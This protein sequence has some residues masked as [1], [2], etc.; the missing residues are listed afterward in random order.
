MHLFVKLPLP[1]FNTPNSL[2]TSGSSLKDDAGA[3]VRA[4]LR[5]AGLNVDTLVSW[6]AVEGA[7]DAL[8]AEETALYQ[9]VVDVGLVRD[10]TASTIVT[11]RGLVGCEYHGGL[12]GVQWGPLVPSSRRP[13]PWRSNGRRAAP[14]YGFSTRRRSRMLLLIR[15]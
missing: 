5:R 10:G 13:C 7:S 14:A 3:T 1:P 8:E 4:A 11:V 6:A 15:G 12:H 9:A 2:V